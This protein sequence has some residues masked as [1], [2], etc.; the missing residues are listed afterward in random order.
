[1]VDLLPTPRRIAIVAHSS[2]LDGM[3]NA[4]TIAKFLTEHG[5]ETVGWGT[6]QNEELNK[7]ILSGEF[8]L[9]LA[10]G[11]DGTMLH[12]CS[13]GAPLGLPVL[14]I[15]LG[16]FGFLTEIQRGQWREMLPLLLRGSYWLEERMMLRADHLRG[17]EVLDSWHVIN[18]V[19]VCRGQFVRPIQIQAEINDYLLYTFVADGLIA[20]TPTGSTAYA[21]AAGGPILPPDLRNIL[22]IPVAPHLSMDRAIILSEGSSV[23]M[24]VHTSHEAVMSVDGQLPVPMLDGDSVRVYMNDFTVQFIRFQD[25]GYFYRNITAY[26]EQ[27]PL[28]GN[29]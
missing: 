26:M 11:G 10:L 21:L 9:L 4:Q 29:R 8:D 17:G 5:V 14:G 13:L 27:N 18:E 7:R 12:A 22:I 16:H 1:M 28:T 2:V 20:S 6:F 15:N 19:V 25:P 3:E 24:T 23:N